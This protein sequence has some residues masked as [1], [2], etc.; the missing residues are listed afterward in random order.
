V[1]L[2]FGS[3]RLEVTCPTIDGAASGC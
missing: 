2:G 1:M 3:Q